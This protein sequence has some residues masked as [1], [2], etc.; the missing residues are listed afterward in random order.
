MAENYLYAG[1]WL[2]DSGRAGGGIHRYQ[3]KEN[4]ELELL[5]HVA[6]DVAAGYI[7]ISADKKYLY[8]VNEIKRRP[9]VVKTEGGIYAY[10]INQKDGSLQELNHISSCGVFPNYI[11]LSSDGKYL[12]GIN[13]GS[14]D[15]VI[16]SRKNEEG[17][18]VLEEVYEESS[19]IAVELQEDGS[20]GE[21]GAM[22]LFS[23]EP[24]RYFEW[25]QAAPHPHCIGL[26]PS[27]QMLLVADRG[28]DRI[29]TCHYDAEKRAFVQIHEY[30]TEHGIG[31][32]NCVFHPTLPFVYVVGEVK[33]YVTVYQYNAQTAELTE[34]TSYLT[35]KQELEYMQG[36]D[37]FACAHPSD[38]RIH[39]D[40]GI[41]YVA[42]RGPDTIACFEISSEN[43]LLTLI[44]TVSTEG[45]F[46]WSMD[47]SESGTWL[48]VGNK[49][50]ENISA[51]LLDE[52]HIPRYKREASH[53]ERT[54]CLKSIEI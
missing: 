22:H 23:G 35:E 28:C 8:T 27:D 47:F 26:D 37:F 21:I 11:V 52:K 43:G 42:N 44:E 1:S 20:L 3:I 7:A 38:I 53:I 36:D 15:M 10:A 34:I 24:S 12:Y 17:K 49:V 54:V 51:F 25:F 29:V 32:R 18:Y 41:L 6:E 39:P 14:E 50:G 40:G 16:R 5:D 30:A 33:P 46:P 45:K 48:Y 19:M 31:P 13:Y 9:D 4:G 2:D